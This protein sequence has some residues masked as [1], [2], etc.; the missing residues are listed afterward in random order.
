MGVGV[1]TKLFYSDPL[2]AAYMTREHGVK[3]VVA[4]NED[5]VQSVSDIAFDYAFE[6]LVEHDEE[7][8]YVHPDSEHIFEPQ[9]GDII[10]HGDWHLEVMDVTDDNYSVYLCIDPVELEETDKYVSIIQRNSKPFFMP[11]VE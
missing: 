7:L 10:L 9:E 3:V 8:L 4:D 1:M 11:E 5:V 2:A 6:S